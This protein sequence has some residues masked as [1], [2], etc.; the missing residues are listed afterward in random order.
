M[1]FKRIFDKTST[2]ITFVVAILFLIGSIVAM[3]MSIRTLKLL[4]HVSSHD[5]PIPD[6][7]VKHLPEAEPAKNKNTEYK[8]KDCTCMSLNS[9]TSRLYRYFFLTDFQKGTEL[10]YY[11]KNPSEFGTINP[12]N[13]CPKG[14]F[15]IY[16]CNN[17]KT[18]DKVV[19]S[20]EEDNDASKKYDFVLDSSL[21]YNT[22]APYFEGGRKNVIYG[23][24]TPPYSFISDPV[25]EI[26]LQTMF[27]T[28][29]IIISFVTFIGFITF[30]FIT[31]IFLYYRF[32]FTSDGCNIT[33]TKSDTSTPT[34]RAR[35][36]MINSIRIRTNTPTPTQN[37]NN[38][39][40]NLSN[41]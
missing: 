33:K 30:M 8:L 13:N 40:N 2:S 38:N 1:V 18:Q 3:Y 11:N 28:L 15:T 26:K 41:P 20:C 10:E 14:I 37:N 5:N 22:Y 24:T 9:I 7:T 34:D 27:Y 17:P 21:S 23:N 16:Q 32:N 25:F 19:M 4:R 31:L 12:Y 39:N 35:Y 36:N 6:C 29:W